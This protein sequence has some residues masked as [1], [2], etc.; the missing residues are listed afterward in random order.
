MHFQQTEVVLFVF[1]KHLNFYSIVIP[2]FPV[3]SCYTFDSKKK[4]V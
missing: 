2:V 3:Y 1:V 4:Q